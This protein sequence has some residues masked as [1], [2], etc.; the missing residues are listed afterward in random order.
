MGYIETAIILEESV[1]QINKQKML[2]QFRAGE[3]VAL[4]TNRP[5]TRTSE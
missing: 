2:S 5:L 3:L 4:V 1:T